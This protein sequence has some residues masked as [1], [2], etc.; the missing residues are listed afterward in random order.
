MIVVIT[1]WAPVRALRNPTSPP[2]NAPPSRPATS[3]T[4]RWTNGGR[5]HV[6]PT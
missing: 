6:K 3:A 5:F 2:Q 1:S 4:S